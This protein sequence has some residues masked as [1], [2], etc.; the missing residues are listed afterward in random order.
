MEVREIVI[1]LELLGLE[2]HQT[3]DISVTRAKWPLRPP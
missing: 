1:E 3:A 2:D